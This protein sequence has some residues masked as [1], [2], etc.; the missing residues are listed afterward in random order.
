MSAVT[1]EDWPLARVQRSPLAPHADDL[2]VGWTCGGVRLRRARRRWLDLEEGAVGPAHR[3]DELPGQK[4]LAF[5]RGHADRQREDPPSLALQA[6][7]EPGDARAL[8]EVRVG[9]DQVTL[10]EQG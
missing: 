6:G 5:G 10:D 8:V 9:D 4:C 7:D 1:N 3:A 2:E